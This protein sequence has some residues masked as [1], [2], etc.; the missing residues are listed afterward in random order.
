MFISPMLLHKID[1]PFDDDNYITELKLDGFRT[2]W[3]KFDNKVRIYTRHKNEITSKFPELV[4]IPLPN[5][6]VLDGEIIVTDPQGK[7]DF[8]AVMERF[9]YSKSEH[10]ISFSVF[11][12]IFFNGE[13]ITNLPLL[14][15]K[16]ILEEVIPEDTPLLN[17][18][19][20]IEGNGEQYFE[21]IKQQ[22]LEGIVQKKAN[23]KYQINKRSHDWL[24]VIN[25]H[26]ENVYISGLRKDEFGLL[27]K[28]ENGKYA[29]LMEFMPTPNRKEF[30]KQY[31]DFVVEEN[32]KFVYLDPKLKLKVKYRNLTKKGLLR[33]PSFVEWA[34]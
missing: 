34:N 21:L 2:I 26:Y 17:K 25:Y 22:E 30:Y 23:S 29:G 8:E 7:P 14:E 12:I 5:G 18:V 16:E 31:G 20:W 19:Q 1:H 9:M 15:R 4:N 33:I 13:K 32:D 3:T 6:T 11:D 10:Q 24:K 27:L 28:F